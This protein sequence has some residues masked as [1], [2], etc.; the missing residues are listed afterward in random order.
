MTDFYVFQVT[1]AGVDEA[2]LLGPTY[3]L[4]VNVLDSDGRW[5]AS[6]AREAIGLAAKQTGRDDIYAAFPAEAAVVERWPLATDHFA[7]YFGRE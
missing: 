7:G 5:P 6:D 4:V 2:T 1:E 3:R